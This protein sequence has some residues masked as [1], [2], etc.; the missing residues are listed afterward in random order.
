MFTELRFEHFADRRVAVPGVHP[1]GRSDDPSESGGDEPDWVEF[2]RE[3]RQG[4]GCC[5]GALSAARS[6]RR[7]VRRGWGWN[8]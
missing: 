7:S 4:P 5:S 6:S 8:R 3:A 2:N 1:V